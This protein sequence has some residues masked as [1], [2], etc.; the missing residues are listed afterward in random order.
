MTGDEDGPGV[1]AESGADGAGGAGF[2]DFAGDFAVGEALAAGDGGGGVKNGLLEGGEGGPVEAVSPGGPGDGEIAGDAAADAAGVVGA[3]VAGEFG[4][5]GG[6]D[7]GVEVAFAIAEG[8]I[9]EGVAG[10][11]LAAEFVGGEAGGE[12][13]AEAGVFG[14]FD[15]AGGDGGGVGFDDLPDEGA[16]APGGGEEGHVV[17]GVRRG[18]SGGCGAE[19]DG[20]GG[21]GSGRFSFMSCNDHG[22]TPF[23]LALREFPLS[24]KRLVVR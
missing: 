20:A 5:P 16:E 19:E 15:N 4:E 9:A 3:E 23:V 2:S 17:A 18:G 24:A 14:F 7:L 22:L 21:E 8:F 13:A 11:D 10:E 6:D 1:G 12:D